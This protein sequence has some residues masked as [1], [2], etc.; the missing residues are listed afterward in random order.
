MYNERTFMPN[1]TQLTESNDL[2][3]KFNPENTFL[4]ND[5]RINLNFHFSFINESRRKITKYFN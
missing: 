3:H 2:P 1:V 4:Q 5:K